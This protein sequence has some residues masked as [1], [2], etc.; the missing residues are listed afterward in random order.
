MSEGRQL[1]SPGSFKGLRAWAKQ[2]KLEVLTLFFALKHPYTPWYAK[3]V[4]AVVVGYAL[5]PID[6]V[7][8]FIPILGYLDDVILLPVGIALALRLIPPAIL[9]EC[10][11]A[12]A[13]IHGKLP[14]LWLA[15]VVIILLWLVVVFAIVKA[16]L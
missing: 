16:L 2:L 14:R 10:R 1:T 13:A 4:A 9:D 15:A 3:A 12:A 8:D 6:L 5:S 7:P 11:Q